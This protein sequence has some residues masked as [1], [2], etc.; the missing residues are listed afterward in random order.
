VQLVDADAPV[1]VDDVAVD[2]SVPRPRVGA[3]P[4]VAAVT[5]V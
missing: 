5:R 2:W 1:G 3:S 4:A